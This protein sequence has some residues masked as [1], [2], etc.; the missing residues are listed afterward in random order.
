MISAGKHLIYLRIL[1]LNVFKHMIDIPNIQE[2]IYVVAPSNVSSSKIV[3]H[4]KSTKKLEELKEAIDRTSHNCVTL[5]GI[6]L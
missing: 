5:K 4:F 6:I 2:I 3:T 1:I